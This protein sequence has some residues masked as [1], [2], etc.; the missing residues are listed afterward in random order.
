MP[1][2]CSEIVEVLKKYRI[3]KSLSKY[4]LVQICKNEFGYETTFAYELVNRALDQ[5]AE[6]QKEWAKG[7]L[8]Q[9]LVALEELLEDAKKHKDRRLML[10]TI[11]DINKL[12]GLYVERKDITSNGKT[13]MV[14]VPD[15]ND[16]MD[17]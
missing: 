9:Q 6:I 3:E 1:Q 7:A 17:E 10:E 8:E 16:D 14:I 13:I 4:S 12:K 5:V 2:D 15:E 11:K